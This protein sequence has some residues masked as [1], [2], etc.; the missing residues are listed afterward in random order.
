MMKPGPRTSKNEWCCS[1]GRRIIS[2]RKPASQRAWDRRIGGPPACRAPSRQAGRSSCLA[3]APHPV[4]PLH[5]HRTTGRPRAVCATGVP[6]LRRAG[7]VPPLF[8]TRCRAS[9]GHAARPWAAGGGPALCDRSAAQSATCE[10]RGARRPNRRAPN[11]EGGAAC[12]EGPAPAVA[13]GPA[14]VAAP[15]Q[16]DTRH[17]PDARPPSGPLRLHGAGI[18]CCPAA[19]SG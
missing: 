7:S 4:Q 17:N 10:G 18:P 16:R 2:R 19:W 8:A 11:R 14:R 1:R 9:D 13:H 15:L 12:R 5:Q 3:A 6:C